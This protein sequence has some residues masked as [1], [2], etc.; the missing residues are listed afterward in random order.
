[1]ANTNDISM[2]NDGIAFAVKLQINNKG[3]V[4]L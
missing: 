2:L 3:E 4:C 1:M